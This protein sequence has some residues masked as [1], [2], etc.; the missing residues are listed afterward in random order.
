CDGSPMPATYIRDGLVQASYLAGRLFECGGSVAS[1]RVAGAR[2]R[3]RSEAQMP[4]SPAHPV[5][6]SRSPTMTTARMAATAGSA[7]VSVVA[8]L[9]LTRVRPYPKRR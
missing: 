1:S 5:A 6:G 3:T 9:A 4:A 2:E 7:R 8:V